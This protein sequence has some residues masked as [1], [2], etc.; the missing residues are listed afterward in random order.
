MM[1]AVSLGDKDLRRL[2]GL[3]GALAEPAAGD[4]VIGL[5][6]SV[7]N[8]VRSDGVS[9][10][11]LDL[12]TRQV[13]SSTTT[14]DQAADDALEKVFWAHYDEHPL[15]HGRGAA[16]PVAAFGDVVTR[17]ELHRIALYHEY[18]R[19]LG[20]EHLIKVDLGH[21][22]GQTN[23]ILLERAGG[24]DFDDRDHLVLAL[25]RPHLAVAT[26]RLT[27]SPP[28][29]TP[30]EREVLTLVRQGLTNHSVARH[31]RV[32]PNTVR[33]HLENAY[34]RLGVQSRTAAVIAFTDGVTGVS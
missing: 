4:D 30:R 16:M 27:T 15:C 32:S 10:S 23:V 6:G 21:P 18:L 9:W 12:T 11:R 2:L 17:R 33:K 20:T 25:L 1:A 19:P 31:L 13:L 7:A 29:L 5:L 3:A 14:T 8:L 24:R 22:P 28:K 34:T 26:R